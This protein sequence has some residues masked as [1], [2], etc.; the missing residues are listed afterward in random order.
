MDW[1][2][3]RDP[4]SSGVDGM[5]ERVQGMDGPL[6]IWNI[7]KETEKSQDEEIKKSMKEEFDFL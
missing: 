2:L 6:Q 3:S 4:L 7:P 1:D 5:T